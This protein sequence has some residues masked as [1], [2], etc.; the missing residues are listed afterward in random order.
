MTK[1]LFSRFRLQC[2]LGKL[3]KLKKPSEFDD[4]NSDAVYLFKEMRDTKCV[5]DQTEIIKRVTDY[6]RQCS[7]YKGRFRRK[8]EFTEQFDGIET[9]G[10][11]SC[12]YSAISLLFFGHHHFAIGLRA[13]TAAHMAI[14]EPLCT[15]LNTVF[16]EKVTWLSILDISRFAESTEIIFLSNILCRNIIIYESGSRIWYQYPLINCE[17]PKEPLYLHLEE[18]HFSALTKKTEDPLIEASIFELT[19]LPPLKT[20]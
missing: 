16:H 20:V 7:L 9:P 10:K 5:Q 2:I 17:L 13:I 19:D 15:H 14:N 8:W 6:I 4:I 12:F 3:M 18:Q 11:G 1:N